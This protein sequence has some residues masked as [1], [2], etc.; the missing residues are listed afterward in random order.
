MEESLQQFFRLLKN[1][2]LP[3]EV[4]MEV[5][6]ISKQLEANPLLLT[7]DVQIILKHLE[8]NAESFFTPEA[9]KCTIRAAG[10]R[11]EGNR[12]YERKQFLK[13]LEKYNESI[14]MAPNNSANLG[15]GYANRSAVYYEMK[16]YGLAIANIELA[17]KHHYPQHLKPNLYDRE[18]NCRLKHDKTDFSWNRSEYVRLIG[19]FDVVPKPSLT[20][21]A[22][23]IV[24]QEL[25]TG[26]RAMVAEKDFAAGECILQESPLIGSVGWDKR[27]TRCNFCFSANLLNLIPCSSCTSVMFCNELCMKAGQR[28][29][30]FECGSST[31]MS[32]FYEKWIGPRLFFHGLSLFECDFGKMMTFCRENRGSGT[33]FST[34]DYSKYDPKE[35]FRMFLRTR[36]EHPS[37]ERLG[38]TIQNFFAVLF[39]KMYLNVPLV[40]SL[41][42]NKAQENFMLQCFLDFM[43]ITQRL[44]VSR[45]HEGFLYPVASDFGQSCD[46]NAIVLG[47]G[48]YMQMIVLRP[49]R[50]G[51]QIVISYDVV[52]FV[53]NPRGSSSGGKNTNSHV[54]SIGI[55]CWRCSGLQATKI[56]RESK[57]STQCNNSFRNMVQTIHRRT[58]PKWLSG[59][60]MNWLILSGSCQW[61]RT[62]VMRRQII[63]IFLE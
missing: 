20:H 19:I 30:R 62:I 41:V 31:N 60:G 33:L 52:L 58:L 28:Q 51:E 48:R 37:Y 29:H 34:L 53:T 39:F 43:H 38:S 7:G 36:V 63:D 26:D 14:C 22:K 61:L 23:G 11:Q 50:R 13:S 54:P 24:N 45:S 2:S 49:I 17:L 5:D 9:Q 35:E 15:I 25:P 12:L 55:A 3:R 57:E 8:S 21:L 27:F 56:Y 59:T 1:Q 6:Y 16:M 10:L 4:F 40:R 44:F 18:F 46:P 47:S 42:A 32:R